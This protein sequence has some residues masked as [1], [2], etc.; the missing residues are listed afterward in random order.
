MKKYDCR[1]NF[2]WREV[3]KAV[4]AR[5]GGVCEIRSSRCD[6]R[7]VDYHHIIFKSNGGKDTAENI[8]HSCLICHR[9]IHNA[10]GQKL[11]N[12]MDKIGEEMASR[13]MW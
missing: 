8:K 11:S 10:V 13:I 12:K 7:A 3:K 5:S 2:A 6:G 9:A 1:D 4:R